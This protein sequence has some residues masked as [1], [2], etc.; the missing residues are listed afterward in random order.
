MKTQIFYFSATGN[1]LKVARDLALA[2][3][4]AQILSI[5][6]VIDKELDLSADCIGLVYP[7]YMF[8]MPLVVSRFIARL[9][10]APGKYFFSVATCGG[11]AGL[12]LK[13]NQKIMQEYGLKLSAGFIVKMPGNYTPLYGA[14]PP[15]K[16]AELFRKE[17]ERVK[18]IASL[19]KDKSSARIESDMFLFGWLFSLIYKIASPKIPVLDKD[20]YAD[21][22]CD[23][24]GVCVKVCP[25]RNIELFEGK[26]KWFHKCEQCFACLHWCPQK[27][28]QYGK[29]TA[30]RTRYHH[31]E[32]K[33]QDIAI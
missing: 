4:G 26:P 3:G 1:S 29:S 19:I 13:Q 2:L 16:Q 23:S 31:P 32:I 10:A 27:A 22:K 6:K 24:C 7:V 11:K 5:P 17:E 14:L 21:N 8:G 25:V 12:T 18:Y 9:K 30:G 33:V 28:I 20:F 15:E